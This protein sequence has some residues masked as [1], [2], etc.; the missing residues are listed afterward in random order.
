MVIQ[1]KIS[2]E[3]QCPNCFTESIEKV[4]YQTVIHYQMLK[5]QDKIIVGLSGG[6]DSMSLL[7]NIIKI[8]EKIR[9]VEPII[10]LTIDE[11]IRDY[12][13][14]SIEDAKQYCQKY[15]IQHEIIS[16][17]ERVG[18]NLDEILLLKKGTDTERYTCNYC[19][20]IRR[21][22]LNEEAKNLGGTVL[23][24]GHNLT[25]VTETFLMN[26]LHKRHQLIAN[27]YLFKTETAES[28]KYYIKKVKPL[29]KIP[30]EEIFLYANLKHLKYYPSHCP[31]R[32]EDPILRKR[33]LDYILKIKTILPEVEYNLFSSFQRISEKLY[34]NLPN[35]EFQECTICGYPSGKSQVCTYC[36][37]T[38]SLRN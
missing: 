26:I 7:Y 12:R 20:T 16:F 13:K 38:E 1:K 5:P 27:Q 36:N 30:E 9:N 15:N 3:F 31:Y 21:R 28:K 11:G 4:I 35:Q 8:K 19:A 14:N 33:V 25:D 22:L 23:A 18:N 2:G 32:E 10:A 24:L 34:K 37:L 6:K 29:I 17:K